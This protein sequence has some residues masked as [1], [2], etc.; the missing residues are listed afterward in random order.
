M[1]EKEQLRRAAA[2]HFGCDPSELRIVQVK[3]SRSFSRVDVDF[4]HVEAVTESGEL[5]LVQRTTRDER[6][7]TWVMTV[8]SDGN[9]REVL[10]EE[11]LGLPT[12]WPVGRDCGGLSGD[13]ALWLAA[14]MYGHD[15]AAA[16]AD[17]QQAENDPEEHARLRQSLRA[18][19][20]RNSD[21]LK[22][23]SEQNDLAAAQRFKTTTKPTKQQIREARAT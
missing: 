22:V 4:E 19:I 8:D 1:S 12:T 21:R 6:T 9:V 14:Q 7:S 17:I 18:R 23:E 10:K 13:Y 15:G 16:Y 11:L 3:K 5:V 2:D 20:K